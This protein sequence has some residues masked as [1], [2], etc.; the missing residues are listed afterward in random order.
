MKKPGPKPLPPADRI[1]DTP[2]NV[3]KAICQVTP[4]RKW[5]YEKLRRTASRMDATDK[6]GVLR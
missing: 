4:K 2:E 5:R 1:P 6:T 3:A